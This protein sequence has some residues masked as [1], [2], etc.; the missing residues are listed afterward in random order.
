MRYLVLALFFP[1]ASSAQAPSFSMEFVR[2]S[3][4]EFFMGCSNGDELCTENEKPAHRVRITKPFE[5]ARFEVTQAQ[6]A[7]IMGENYS[8]FKGPDRP[9]ENVSW[10][11]AQEF[12]R[13]LTARNDGYLYRLP[14]EA[15]WEYAAR[16]GATEAFPGVAYELGWYYENSNEQTHPVGTKKPNAWGVYDM[17]G[18][19][20][21]WMQDW[22]DESYYRAGDDIDPIGPPSGRYRTIRGGSWVDTVDNARVSKRDYFAD[23]LDFHIGFRCVRESTRRLI[24]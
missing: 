18:N 21:E 24:E 1:L 4:G 22:Y 15:E 7:A 19:V 3:P 10:Q 20:Y 16:A 17:S 13:R 14:T 11:D 12:L 23:S 6:W 5:I 9:V 2:I 8:Q